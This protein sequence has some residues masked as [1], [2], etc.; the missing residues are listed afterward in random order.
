MLHA[1]YKK[2]DRDSEQFWRKNYH[3]SKK[4]CNSAVVQKID[5]KCKSVNLLH[6]LHMEDENEKMMC[7][8][9]LHKGNLGMQ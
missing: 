2:S 9:A 1:I 7:T 4:C 6:S 8:S 3:M 5:Q